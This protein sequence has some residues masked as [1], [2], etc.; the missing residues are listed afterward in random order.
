MKKFNIALSILV[1]IT[2]IANM[3]F[4]NTLS[5]KGDVMYKLEKQFV[6]LKKE[7]DNLKYVYFSN[8]SLSELSI[9]ANL[10]GFAK[11][12]YEYDQKPQFASVR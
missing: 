10:D 6:E 2:A 12:N 9:R 4:S 7:N 1:I 5:V 11:A 8:S 3:Y